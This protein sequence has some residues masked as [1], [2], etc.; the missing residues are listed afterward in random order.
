MALAVAAEFVRRSIAEWPA[1]RSS[2]GS[3]IE[4]LVELKRLGEEGV[5]PWD[6]LNAMKEV[7]LDRLRKQYGIFNEP[8]SPSAY[9]KD[10]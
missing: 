5:V 3:P 2:R 7:I 1:T 10:Y 6:Q 9:S 4:Q 8:D